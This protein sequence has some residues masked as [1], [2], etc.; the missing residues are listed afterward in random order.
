M[1]ILFSLS[2][3][4]FSFVS[5]SWMCSVLPTSMAIELLGGESCLGLLGGRCGDGSGV[6]GGMSGEGVGCWNIMNEIGAF[7]GSPKTTKETLPDSLYLDVQ[8]K[9]LAV[10]AS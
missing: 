2:L 4:L 3:C 5:F 10:L 1:E 7:R 6:G 9:G 8:L